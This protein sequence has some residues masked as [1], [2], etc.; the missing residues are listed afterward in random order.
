[1]RISFTE[2]LCFNCGFKWT[3]SEGKFVRD[4]AK[5]LNS[6]RAREADR[7][8]CI[9]KDEKDVGCTHFCITLI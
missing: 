6:F 1:M 2:L 7:K 5:H 9:K 3:G 8:V 4:V